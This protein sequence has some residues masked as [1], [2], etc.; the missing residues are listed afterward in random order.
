MFAFAHE[1]MRVS[2]DARNRI[3]YNTIPHAGCIWDSCWQEVIETLA[4]VTYSRTIR[5]VTFEA[6]SFGKRS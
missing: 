1:W 2:S 5:Q 3:E 4:V 6:S